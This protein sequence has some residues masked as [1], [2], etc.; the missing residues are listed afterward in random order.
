MQT[1]TTVSALI[2]LWFV[3]AGVAGAFAPVVAYLMMV[4]AYAWVLLG[5]GAAVLKGSWPATFLMEDIET[6]RGVVIF[7]AF[8]FVVHTALMALRLFR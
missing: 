1:S 6:D 4:P 3:A 2:I 8:G 7:F 5:N